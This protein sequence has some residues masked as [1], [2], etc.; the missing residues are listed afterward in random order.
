MDYELTFQVMVDLLVPMLMCCQGPSGE[1]GRP[2]PSGPIGL[3]GSPGSMGIVGPRG[4]FVS[5][6]LLFSL[7]YTGIKCHRYLFQ[8]LIELKSKIRVDF[9]Y[10][11]LK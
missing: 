8:L 5:T 7:Q 1:D 10:V 4:H 2:G 6:H 9:L 11:L 3:R